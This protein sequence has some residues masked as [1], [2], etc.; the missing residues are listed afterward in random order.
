MG[1]DVLV[2]GLVGSYM[3]VAVGVEAGEDAGVLQSTAACGK[4]VVEHP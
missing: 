4:G 1:G 2:Q 3:V